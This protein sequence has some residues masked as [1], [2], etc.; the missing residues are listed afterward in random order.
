MP[1]QEFF[2]VRVAVPDSWENRSAVVFVSP[3]SKLT[4]PMAGAKQQAP[5]AAAS[6]VMGPPQEA[7]GRGAKDILEEL[8]AAAKKNGHGVTFAAT[9]SLTRDDRDIAFTQCRA[10]TS[11]GIPINQLHAVI[12]QWGCSVSFTGSFPLNEPSA[13]RDQLIDILMSITLQQANG[14]SC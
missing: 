10:S 12:V 8:M 9:E 4:A 3:P 13:T 14:A 11:D 7:E 6:I 5:L 1:F 2:G